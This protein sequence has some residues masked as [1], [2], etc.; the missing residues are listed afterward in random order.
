MQVHEGAA[1]VATRLTEL[2][3]VEQTLRDAVQDGLH[4]AFLCTKHDP[5]PLPGFLAWGKTMRFLRDHLVP[6][7]WTNSNARNYAT[8]ITPD[9]SFAITV[10]AGDSNTGRT[11]DGVVPTTRSEKGPA[12]RDAVNR[13]QLSFADISEDFPRPKPSATQTW[14]VLHHADETA[15]EIRIELSLPA[16]MTKDGF[17]TEW[18]ERIILTPIPLNAA[19]ETTAE[20]EVGDEIEV[21]V[22]RRTN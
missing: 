11:Q 8:V 17:V 10:A 2:G 12:T 5:P 6:L 4:H 3:L 13:N 9:G 22:E 16:S 1:V 15:G 19:L 18:R 14:L 20:P 7:G 21:N